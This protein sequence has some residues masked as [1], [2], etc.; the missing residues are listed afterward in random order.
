MRGNPTPRAGRRPVARR[1]S[2]DIAHTLPSQLE[3][4]AHALQREEEL[5]EGAVLLNQQFRRQVANASASHEAWA[6][7]RQLRDM[8]E[9]QVFEEN[10]GVSR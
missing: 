5:E 7:R 2:P 10:L 3:S 4:E 9:V 8:A 1:S 6:L